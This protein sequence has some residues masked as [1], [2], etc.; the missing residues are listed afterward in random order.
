MKGKLGTERKTGNLRTEIKTSKLKG[1]Q[2]LR[3]KL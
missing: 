2:V 1:I 3:D